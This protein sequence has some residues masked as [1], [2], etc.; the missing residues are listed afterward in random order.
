MKDVKLT[1]VDIQK[2]KLLNQQDGKT[3]KTEQKQTK[4]QLNSIAQWKHKYI[5]RK[6][7]IQVTF[8]H[9]TLTECPLLNTFGQKNYK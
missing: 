4:N 7:L 3:P 2:I 8:E 6:N 1:N 9:I 5:E